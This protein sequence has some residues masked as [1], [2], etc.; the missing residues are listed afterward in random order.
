MVSAWIVLVFYIIIIFKSNR[1]LYIL[2]LMTPGGIEKAS[3]FPDTHTHTH[4]HKG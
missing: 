1:L 3:S 4:F 2:S